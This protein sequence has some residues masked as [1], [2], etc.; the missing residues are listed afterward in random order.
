V[1]EPR[2]VD[3]LGVDAHRRNVGLPAPAY[4]LDETSLA[5]V[6]DGRETAIR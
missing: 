4:G 2:V 3:G 6:I 1:P 5:E